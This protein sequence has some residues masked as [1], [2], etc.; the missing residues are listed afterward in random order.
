MTHISVEMLKPNAN[1][2]VIVIKSQ[3]NIRYCNLEC[4]DQKIKIRLNIAQFNK[5][6]NKIS[7]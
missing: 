7:S 5:S 2:N 6:I 3:I 4:Y 1:L